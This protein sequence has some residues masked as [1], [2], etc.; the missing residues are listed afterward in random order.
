MILNN[1]QVKRLYGQLAPLYD[2]TLLPFRLLGLDR[3][4]KEAIARLR[5]R[6][7]DTV[8]DMGGGTGLNLP[9]LYDYVG[10]AG[11]IICVDLSSAMLGRARERVIRKGFSNVELVQADLGSYDFP[12]KI[13]G[14]VAT[15]SLEMIPAYDVI[16]RSVAARLPEG[17]RMASYGLK[18]PAKWPDW[19][20]QIGI[21][22]T[23]PFGTSREYMSFRPWE[24]IR[25]HLKEV[26]YREF[27]FGAAYLSVGESRKKR[28]LQNIVC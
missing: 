2:A 7:G 4:R 23:K 16:V 1:E 25:R 24:S 5:L 8:V 6:P 28:L 17:R 11:R 26:E 9:I 10:P 14:A 20:V 3:Q 19:L 21:F 13:G 18:Q 15:Y 12:S 27:L 22:L